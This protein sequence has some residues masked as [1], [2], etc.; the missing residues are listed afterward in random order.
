MGDDLSLPTEYDPIRVED[1]VAAALNASL[2]PRKLEKIVLLY[3]SIQPYITN[4][5]ILSKLQISSPTYSK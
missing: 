3:H 1:F 4:K 5:S 2:Q